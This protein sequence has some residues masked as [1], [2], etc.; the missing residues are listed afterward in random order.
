MADI[1]HCSSPTTSSTER[2]LSKLFQSK[3]KREREKGMTALPKIGK[4]TRQS[5]EKRMHDRDTREEKGC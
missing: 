2:Y 4:N 3:G 1:L 5:G